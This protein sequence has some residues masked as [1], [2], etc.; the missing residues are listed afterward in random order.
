MAPPVAGEWHSA[1]ESH[2]AA[3]KQQIALISESFVLV[4]LDGFLSFMDESGNSPTEFI[5]E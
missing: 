5:I 3:K 4:F 2:L 1:T